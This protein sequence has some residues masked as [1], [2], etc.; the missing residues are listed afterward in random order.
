M[1]IE[2]MTLTLPMLR[3]TTELQGRLAFPPSGKAPGRSR[4]TTEIS[5]SPSIKILSKTFPRRE[6]VRAANHRRV[7]AIPRTA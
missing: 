4:G 7:S 6:S 1:G 2:P 3:S 5:R